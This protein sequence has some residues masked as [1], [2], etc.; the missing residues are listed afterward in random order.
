[1]SEYQY[2]EFLAVDYPLNEHQL[3]EL[4]TL[5]TRAL[6][7]P[8]S[9]VNTYHWGSFRGDP[10]KLIETYFDAFLYLANWG[11]RQLMIRLPARLLDLETA[12]RYCAGEAVTTWAAGDHV[13][14]S[15]ASEQEEGHWMMTC[16]RLPP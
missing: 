6:L 5:S 1:M 10:R 9:L 15:L 7:T 14:L 11:T 4:S 16:S 8:T 3:A 13:I 2:Y 12:A